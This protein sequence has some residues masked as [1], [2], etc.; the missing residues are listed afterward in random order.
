MNYDLEFATSLF[1][2]K[3]FSKYLLLVR[4]EWINT[5]CEVKKLSLARDK[6]DFFYKLSIELCVM[7]L[8]LHSFMN[9]F[10]LFMHGIPFSK[11]KR[12]KKIILKV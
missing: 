6:K 3:I 4:Y 7:K 9:D 5:T 2:C 10:V 8:V 1:D 11:G 12:C